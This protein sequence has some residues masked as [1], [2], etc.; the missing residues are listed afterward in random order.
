MNVDDNPYASPAAELGPAHRRPEDLSDAE[1]IR[2]EHLKH[3]ASIQSVGQLYYIATALI[4]FGAVIGIADGA[5]ALG[6]AVV[7]LAIL[8]FG[9]IL[10]LFL[11]GRGLRRLDRSVRGLAGVL[12]GIGLL[13]FPF[14]TII[15]AYILYLLFSPKGR[16]VFSPEYREIIRLT[17]HIK[18]RTSIIVMVF[19]VL[20]LALLV[21]GAVAPLLLHSR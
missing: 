21:M 9:L 2:H 4:T 3:E 14:G 13:G 15:N 5:V 19:A 16:F 20:L 12:S 18:Y 6:G 7:L 11:L 8:Y 17:P 1:R 10:V